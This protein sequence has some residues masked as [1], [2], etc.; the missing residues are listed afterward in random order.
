MEGNL[1]WNC[2]Y[3]NI[4][5]PLTRPKDECLGYEYCGRQIS[6][7]T[8]GNYIGISR[9]QVN[10]IIHKFSAN[11]IIEMLAIRGC[12]VRYEKLYNQLKF[13][14]LERETQV[15]SICIKSTPSALCNILELVAKELG[16]EATAKEAILW[17]KLSGIGGKNTT[18]SIISKK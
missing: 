11:K 16:E 7:T 6:Q 9:R 3:I 10:Y 17:M 13:Y 4:C 8:I 5:N 12:T 2:R 15:M 18:H 1:C 14:E